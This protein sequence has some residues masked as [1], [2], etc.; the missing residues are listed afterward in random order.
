[1]NDPKIPKSYLN[2]QLKKK[3]NFT[4]TQTQTQNLKNIYV[5][6]E[7]YSKYSNIFNIHNNFDHV[8]GLTLTQTKTWIP[9]KYLLGNFL[10]IRIQ[11]KPMFLSQFRFDF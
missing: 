9:K 6:P 8:L 4:E 5:L 1:M 2:T 11:T 7:T 3:R 10:S